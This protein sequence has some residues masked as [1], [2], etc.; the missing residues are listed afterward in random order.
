MWFRV[1]ASLAVLL[2]LLTGC[3]QSEQESFEGK[4][5][6]IGKADSILVTTHDKHM[7]K[8]RIPKRSCLI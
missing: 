3:N 1:L 5:F 7:E 6:K 2:G 8:M 4:I